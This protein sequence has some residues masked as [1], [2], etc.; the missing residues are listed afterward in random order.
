MPFFFRL[1]FFNDYYFA[2]DFP[3]NKQILF[4]IDGISE[5]YFATILSFCTKPC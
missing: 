5:M 1:T 2:S 3:E 4:D